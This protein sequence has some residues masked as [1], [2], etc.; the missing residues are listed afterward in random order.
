MTSDTLQLRDVVTRDTLDQQLQ[1]RIERRASDIR[2]ALN[3][4]GEYR[5]NTPQGTVVIRSRKKGS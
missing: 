5:I 3:E 2:R 1:R 4:S